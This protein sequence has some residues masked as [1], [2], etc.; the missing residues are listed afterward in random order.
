[1]KREKRKEKRKRKEILPKNIEISH[2][3]GKIAAKNENRS[4]FLGIMCAILPGRNCV[5]AHMMCEKIEKKRRADFWPF[6]P[7]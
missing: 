2:R 5:C 4:K 7:A 6:S 3:K 1:M